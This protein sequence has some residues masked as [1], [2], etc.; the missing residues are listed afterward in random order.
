MADSQDDFQDNP[1]DKAAPKQRIDTSEDEI[2]LA[3]YLRILWNRRF[4]ILFGSLLPTLLAG[5]FFF[6]LPENY[7]VT[8]IYDIEQDR[9]VLAD[10]LYN[11]QEVKELISKAQESKP[12][13]YKVLRERFYSSEN[14]NRLAAQLKKSSS[15]EYPPDLSK[16]SI[17]LDISGKLLTLTVI[18]SPQGKVQEIS[19]V[20]RDNLEKV[21]PVYS[22]KD[23][24]DSAITE[25]KNKMSDIEKNRFHLQLDLDKKRAILAKLKNVIKASSNSMPDGV[26]IH[27]N[28]IHDSSE[29][30]PLAYQVQA[31]DSNIINIEETINVNKAKYNYYEVL[32]GLN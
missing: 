5:L 10:R 30:L 29:Y 19:A 4:F 2:D 25:F 22:V 20:V 14:M 1:S 3:D 11:L 9:E 13:E 6:L 7:T 28:D 21:I 15:Y 18:D 23:K 24:L 26:I 27:F 31:A 17:K 8:Y 12:Y 32:L 16:T